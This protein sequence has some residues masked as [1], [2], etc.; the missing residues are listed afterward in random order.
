MATID[1]IRSATKVAILLLPWTPAWTVA[2]RRPEDSG[3][4]S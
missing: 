3:L 4:E 2:G 1:G